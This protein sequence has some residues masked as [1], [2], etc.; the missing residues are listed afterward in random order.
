MLPRWPMQPPRERERPLLRP[1]FASL[2]CGGTAEL[3]SPPERTPARIAARWSAKLVT[4]LSPC[5]ALRGPPY[6]PR[7]P[8]GRCPPEAVR[9][10]RVPSRPEVQ[11]GQPMLPGGPEHLGPHHRRKGQVDTARGRPLCFDSG[12]QR[13]DNARAL[14]PRGPQRPSRVCW[15][16]PSGPARLVQ[17]CP[18]GERLRRPS[19]ARAATAGALEVRSSRPTSGPTPAPSGP[20]L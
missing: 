11:E 10:P 12:Q 15:R 18:G 16:R 7:A 2:V 1:P 17:R 20:R 6:C 19:L 4:W 14:L 5:A 13:L 8:A 3:A 9:S